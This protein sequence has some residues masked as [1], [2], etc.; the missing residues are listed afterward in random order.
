MNSLP[1]HQKK[2][3]H[4]WHAAF[5]PHTLRVLDIDNIYT[6][7]HEFPVDSIA[8]S[9]EGKYVAT[10]CD[11][12]ACVFDV[13]NGSK[14]RDIL[15]GSYAKDICFS[16]DGRHL[17]ICSDYREIVIWSIDSGTVVCTLRGHKG[18]INAVKWAAS[19][20][21]IAS[22]SVDCTVRLW[23]WEDSGEMFT[24]KNGNDVTS[25]SISSDSRYVAAGSYDN[26][27][28][29]WDC[30]NGTMVQSFEGLD[31]HQDIVYDVTFTPD[32]THLISASGDRTIKIWSMLSMGQDGVEGKCKKDL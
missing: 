14:I 15:T 8:F 2:E 18:L 5:N 29:V 25:I 6:F 24:L 28:H 9:S 12:I 32:N 20:K 19:G 31:G 26:A 22:G 21:L 17:A 16:P 7:Q 30:R 27:V 23:N 11:R 1:H 4:D 3:G 13:E 10:A